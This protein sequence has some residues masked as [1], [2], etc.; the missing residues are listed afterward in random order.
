[1]ASR[2]RK[3]LLQ[4]SAKGPGKVPLPDSG[5]YRCEIAH[6]TLFTPKESEKGVSVGAVILRKPHRN[7]KFS[8]ILTKSYA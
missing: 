7:S 4:M 8:V 1:M 3:I 5:F 6:G 2:T